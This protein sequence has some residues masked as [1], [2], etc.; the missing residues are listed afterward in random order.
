MSVKETFEGI[1][2]TVCLVKFK[3]TL[4]RQQSR[5]EQYECQVTRKYF[6]FAM[7]NYSK[8]NRY[9]ME[10]Y[11]KPNRYLMSKS[12]LHTNIEHAFTFYGKAKVKSNVLQ[13]KKHRTDALQNM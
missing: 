6:A 12:C 2:S 7:E 9:L 4:A 5:E 10:N 8:P 3:Q 13:V 1:Y 11:S